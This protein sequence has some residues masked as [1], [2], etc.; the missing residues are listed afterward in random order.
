MWPM[1]WVSTCA[2]LVLVKFQC[3]RG[4]WCGRICHRPCIEL[5][6]YLFLGVYSAVSVNMH[7]SQYKFWNNQKRMCPSSV[8]FAWIILFLLASISLCCVLCQLTME[9]SFVCMGCT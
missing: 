7:C 3:N 2:R 4:C 1:G 9:G 8:S 6:C 5:R